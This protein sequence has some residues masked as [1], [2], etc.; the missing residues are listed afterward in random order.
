VLQILMFTILRIA[1]APAICMAHAKATMNLP[2]LSHQ[3]GF[4][5]AEWRIPIDTEIESGSTA[6]MMPVILVWP[7]SRRA[8][9]LRPDMPCR[10]V[11]Q[12]SFP[13][14]SDRTASPAARAI[15]RRISSSLP[16]RFLADVHGLASISRLTYRAATNPR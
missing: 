15:F 9:I 14:G 13:S 11:F 6:R 10:A 1:S 2:V 8:T 4:R 3:N 7:E 5:Y 16:I 12:V